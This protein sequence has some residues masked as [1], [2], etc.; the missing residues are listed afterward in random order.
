MGFVSDN[1]MLGEIVRRGL[2]VGFR[3]P[4]GVGSVTDKLFA[5]GEKGW[6]I[7]EMDGLVGGWV[8]KANR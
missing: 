5:N 1:G 2:K 8:R 6:E 4:G 3:L 7:G